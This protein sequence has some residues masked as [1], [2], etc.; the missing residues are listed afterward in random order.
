MKFVEAILEA[1]EHAKKKKEKTKMPYEFCTIKRKG[2][3]HSIDVCD[4]G[5]I[6]QGNSQFVFVSDIICVDWEIKLDS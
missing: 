5:A 3:N 6:L 4:D 2:N 1:Q